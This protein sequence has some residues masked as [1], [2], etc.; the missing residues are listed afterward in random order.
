MIAISIFVTDFGGEMNWWQVLDDDESFCR[1]GHHWWITNTKNIIKITTSPKS[2]KPKWRLFLSLDPEVWSEIGHLG[3]EYP[4][5]YRLYGSLKM[6]KFNFRLTLG[7]VDPNGCNKVHKL[8]ISFSIC[9]SKVKLWKLFWSNSA[10][11]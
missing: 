11:F 6:I 4:I 7:P 9:N 10:V 1:F 2:L 5:A 8:K 3:L